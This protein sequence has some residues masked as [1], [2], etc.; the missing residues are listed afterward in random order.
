MNE[1]KI[2]FKNILGMWYM[3]K[4]DS[5]PQRYHELSE[6]GKEFF[7]NFIKESKIH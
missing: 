4:N 5:Q 1:M 7:N 3:I 2:E 6:I